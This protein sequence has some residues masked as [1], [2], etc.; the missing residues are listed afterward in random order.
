MTVNIAFERAKL[1]R[2]LKR[3]GIQVEFY[4]PGVN[5]YGE[6]IE[7]DSIGEIRCL[8]HEQNGYVQ[9]VTGDT[10]QTRSKKTP[11][12]LCLYDD[13][14][15]LGLKFGDYCLVENVKYELTEVV[16]IQNWNIIADISLEIVDSVEVGKDADQV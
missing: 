15:E 2:E 3:S 14:Q 8:Y 11:M 1:E 9:I 10:T 6:P 12:L 7:G 4:R 16:N 5:D 13:C